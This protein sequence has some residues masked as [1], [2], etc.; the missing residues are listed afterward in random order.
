MILWIF[1]FD[2]L[3]IR[4]QSYIRRSHRNVLIFNVITLP[5]RK[6]S[7]SSQTSL[8]NAIGSIFFSSTKYFS[9]ENVRNF[10]LYWIVFT[11]NKC[12]LWN[13][14][15]ISR[16]FKCFSL[17]PVALLNAC[18]WIFECWYLKLTKTAMKITTTKL[19]FV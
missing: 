4:S 5:D 2:K 7:F 19:A 1:A 13:R 16:F 11:G 8:S 12:D 9:F 17:S 3:C 10:L 14:S 18:N 6:N 15:V